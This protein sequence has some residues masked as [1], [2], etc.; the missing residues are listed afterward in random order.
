MW[1]KSTLFVSYFAPTHHLWLKSFDISCSFL[2][3]IT[4]EKCQILDLANCCVK[5]NS[6][7]RHIQSTNRHFYIKNT[8]KCASCS[9][10]L[11]Q[12]LDWSFTCISLFVAVKYVWVGLE[13]TSGVF[14]S[15]DIRDMG[16]DIV[17][18]LVIY[19]KAVFG[20]MDFKLS[21]Q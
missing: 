1:A 12:Y 4:K 13:S 10:N 6:C 8:L 14:E 20:T 16:D 19:G 11:Y 5:G 9:A 2:F 7:K 21:L 3:Q 17:I 18:Q 15:S